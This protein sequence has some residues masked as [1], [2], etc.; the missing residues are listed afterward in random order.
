MI[1]FPMRRSESDG[2]GS[3][4]ILTELNRE[5]NIMVDALRILKIIYCFN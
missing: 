3:F 5:E 1:Q 4:R 2:K